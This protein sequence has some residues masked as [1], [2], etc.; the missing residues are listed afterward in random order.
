MF[1]TPVLMTAATLF[2]SPLFAHDPTW[3]L[4]VVFVALLFAALFSA[5]LGFA[6]GFLSCRFVIRSTVNKAGWIRAALIT[7]CVVASLGVAVAAFLPSFRVLCAAFEGKGIRAAFAPAPRAVRR[8]QPPPPIASD[9]PPRPGIPR[10]EF[11]AIEFARQAGRRLENGDFHDGLTGWNVE[12]GNDAF[13]I[14]RRNDQPMVTSYGP[15]KEAC[16]GRIY[17]CFTVPDAPTTLRFFVHGGRDAQARVVA[18]WA[19]GERID[20]VTGKNDNAPFEVRW[21]LSNWKGQT[22][23]L[24]I[25]DEKQGPWGFIGAHGFEL[26]PLEEANENQ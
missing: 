20:R 3:G 26:L 9:P 14:F 13:R 7:L 5:I 21:D 22:V 17:Q 10:T 19:R 16:R 6:F 4:I 25:R 1:I 8:P 24:E 12:D 2:W 18:L 11:L 15:D 23:T